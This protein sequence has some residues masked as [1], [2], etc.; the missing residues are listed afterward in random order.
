MY[1]SGRYLFTFSHL[2]LLVTTYLLISSSF[3]TKRWIFDK[4]KQ[5]KYVTEIKC[6]LFE[7]ET[8]P[9]IDEIGGMIFKSDLENRMTGHS[10]VRDERNRFYIAQ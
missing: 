6:S 10:K 1:P 4:G 3:S 5:S 7:T 8:F 9:L 2:L